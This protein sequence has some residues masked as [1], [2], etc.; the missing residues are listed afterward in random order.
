VKLGGVSDTTNT[1]RETG[2]VKGTR[3][4]NRNLNDSL[5]RLIAWAFPS[6]FAIREKHIATASSTVQ[7]KMTNAPVTLVN[8]GHSVA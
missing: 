6:H 4:K 8:K 2:P 5:D 1:R 7:H 3:Y